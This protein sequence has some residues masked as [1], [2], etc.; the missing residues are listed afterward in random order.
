MRSLSKV[1]KAHEV[2]RM[3]GE[4]MPR[5]VESPPEADRS[6]SAQLVQQQALFDGS[7][8]IRQ[9][10]TEVLALIERVES[11]AMERAQTIA[12]EEAAIVARARQA[13]EAARAE[14]YAKGYEEGM[15]AG[16]QEGVEAFTAVIAAFEGINRRLRAREADLIAQFQQEIVVLAVALAEKLVARSIEDEATAALAILKSLLPQLEGSTSAVIKLSPGAKE[17]LGEHVMDLQSSEG[18]RCRIEWRAD[19]TLGAGDVLIETDW[20]LIDGRLRS[21]WR[22]ILEGLDLKGGPEGDGG[23]EAV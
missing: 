16:R 1:I 6:R 3:P 12:E 10:R 20:G 22:R 21:R 5:P 11:L 19:P 4:E 18:G 17:A 13:A 23:P 15:A 9:A 7:Q 14:G 2:K 8:I